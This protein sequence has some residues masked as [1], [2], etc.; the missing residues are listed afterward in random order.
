MEVDIKDEDIDRAHRI[1]KK[2]KQ[3]GADHQAIIVKFHSWEKRTAVYKG[4]KKLLNKSILLDL[5]HRR[6]LLLSQSKLHVAENV[7][8]EAVFVDVNCRLGLKTV[9]GD[10]KIFQF[11]A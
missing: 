7:G 9:A 10:L 2:Y 5:T 8:I 4:R 1:G 3:G 11:Y 6:A